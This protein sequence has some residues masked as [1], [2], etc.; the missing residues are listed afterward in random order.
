M[1]PI[2]MALGSTAIDPALLSHAERLQHEGYL[3]REA[4]GTIRTLAK[5]GTPI[6]E[7]VR[8][9]GRSGKLVREIVRGVG[10]DVFR[11]RSSI[12]KPHLAWLDAEWSASA[13]S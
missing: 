6:K 9:T 11:C 3:L 4:Y 5:A 13:I 8:R 10:G 1:Q 12:L 2:R 7:I